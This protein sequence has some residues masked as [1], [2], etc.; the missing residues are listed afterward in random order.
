MAQGLEAIAECR[1]IGRLILY[2]YPA[3]H[4][5]GVNVSTA[6][7]VVNY[8]GSQVVVTTGGPTPTPGPTNPPDSES[9]STLYEAENGV[10]SGGTQ[11][12]QT[13][14]GWSGTGKI[15]YFDASVG[16]NCTMTVNVASAGYLSD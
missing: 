7:Q 4:G 9:Q 16:A 13:G 2:G 15:A 3:N 6:D 1:P 12:V 5:N 10:L 14:T 8:S 11:V